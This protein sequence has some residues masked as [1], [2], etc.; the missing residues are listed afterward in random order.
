[1][2]QAVL[3][4]KVAV[5]TGAG[6]GIGRAIAEAWAAAGAA[7]C[8]SA[9]SAAEIEDARAAITRAGGR[10]IAVTADV[11]DWDSTEAL[12]ARAAESFG[13]VDLVL[14]NAGDSMQNEPVE[15]SDPALWRRTVEV[16][17][18][19]TFHTA[20]AAIP[21][22]RRRGGGK[23]LVTGSGMGHRGTPTRS[24]YAASKAGAWM[25][26]RV[27][28]QELADSG[29]CVNEIVPGPVNT[30][31]IAQRAAQLNASTG[32]G[33]WFKE[34]ADVVPLA[35]FLATQPGNGPTGQTFSLARRDL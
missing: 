30:A 23:I 24:A 20:R 29:I 4:G 8:C 5:V 1:M 18:I 26:V 25:L 22:L 11:T 28:A 21:H 14:A 31:F 7:V 13:G 19:G 35:M 34:P 27:L 3:Q 12:L 10:A 32:G 15:R 2:T 17:L 16:N 33:E 9:R 6:R